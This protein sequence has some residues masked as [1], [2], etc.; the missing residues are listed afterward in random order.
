M[1]WNLAADAQYEPHTPGGCTQCLGA[2]TIQ[3]NSITRNVAYYIIAHAAKF[4][5]YGS[6]R[7]ASNMV[8]GLP[9][10]AFLTPAGKKVLI[11]LNTTATTQAF[12]IQFKN[13]YASSILASGSVA[14]YV[15]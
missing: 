13:V 10:V 15:W 12:S 5:P 3:D 14:T 9:N 1:E 7:I 11:V 2:L 6:Y 8:N 4:V